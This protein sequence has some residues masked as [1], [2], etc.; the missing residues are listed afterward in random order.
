MGT[1]KLTTVY[2]GGGTPTTLEPEQ[3]RRLL[4]HIQETFDFT[5]VKE[6][7]VEARTTGQYYKRKTGSAEAPQDSADFD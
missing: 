1:R 7:T 2:I 6:Y 3:L 5:W 4:S